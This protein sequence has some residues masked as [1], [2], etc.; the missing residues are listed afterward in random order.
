M[1][2]RLFSHF[3]AIFSLKIAPSAQNSDKTK[4]PGGRF[5][6]ICKQHTGKTPAV[7]NPIYQAMVPAPRQGGDANTVSCKP[8]HSLMV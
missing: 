7:A 8:S 4:R 5:E 2:L 1:L 3:K 6:E